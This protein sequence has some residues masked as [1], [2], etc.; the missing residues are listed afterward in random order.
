MVHKAPDF[1][2]FQ[3]TLDIIG[4][5]PF[6]FVPAPILAAIFQKAGKEK[7]PIPVHGTV[8]GDAYTQ[9]LV[10]FAAEWR[11]YINM[12]MLKNSPQ[13]VGELL[14]ITIA[15]DGRDRSIIP[16][17]KWVAALAEND[18]A[19][20]VFETL[21]PSRQKEIV[22]YIANLKNEDAVDRNIERALDFLLGKERFVGRD[23]P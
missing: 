8:N 11:L 6:V 17:P 16:H 9:T 22:R 13:R 23:K 18:A 20:A 2:S 14:E 4:V 10:K 5:N 19:S 12:V 3:A 1:F 15:F 21:P 7:G